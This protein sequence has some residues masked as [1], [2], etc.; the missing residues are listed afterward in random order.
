[1]SQRYSKK[2]TPEEK[3]LMLKEIQRDY[4]LL[5]RNYRD[6]IVGEEIYEVEDIVLDAIDGLRY[7]AFRYKTSAQKQKVFRNLKIEI[8]NKAFPELILRIREKS[9]DIS[10]ELQDI[11]AY[12]QLRIAEFID[13]LPAELANIWIYLYIKGVSETKLSRIPGYNI[14]TIQALRAKLKIRLEKKFGKKDVSKLFQTN[15]S[16]GDLIFD[17][18]R[19]RLNKEKKDVLDQWLRASPENRAVLERIRSGNYIKYEE[20]ASGNGS[21]DST[22]MWQK[23]SPF[24]LIGIGVI[25]LSVLTYKF[26]TRKPATP[27][28]EKPVENIVKKPAAPKPID[29]AVWSF[30]NRP[31]ISSDSTR[32]Y[33]LTG[34]GPMQIS[35]SGSNLRFQHIAGR[36]PATVNDNRYYMVRTPI[37]QTHS[38][39]LPDGSM[40]KMNAGSEVRF[41]ADFGP[42]RREL[43]MEGQGYFEAEK[44]GK[45]FAPVVVHVKSPQPLQKYLSE[46]I[47]SVLGTSFDIKANAKDSSIRIV[48]YT[49][50]I[51]IEK[52][53]D[54]TVVLK[55][56]QSFVLDS[57][58]KIQVEPV[59]NMDIDRAW[60]MN[61]F[62][63]RSKSTVYILDELGRTYGHTIT[64]LEKPPGTFSFSGFKSES[65]Y[66]YL[67]VLLKQS[68]SFKYRS[69]NDTI[70]VSR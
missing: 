7:Q 25:L 15:C 61:K 11:Q 21:M 26:F 27:Q 2:T 12:T 19:G 53:G 6:N 55:E 18:L 38:V 51:K 41:P 40:V 35:D 44:P 33:G 47:V 28:N 24:L 30:D 67:D 65:I 29:G 70:Y 66:Y 9:V 8:R 49:G 39:G 69:S 23:I 54:T 10:Q 3:E 63:F 32:K 57:L 31:G 5:L 34:V 43:W 62:D 16:K 48:L 50:K 60:R 17:F 68:N 22:A 4:S 20:P 37:G 46:V 59:V 36:L 13:S 1:M 42:M 14:N 52:P 64:Y 58:G 45:S 56:G